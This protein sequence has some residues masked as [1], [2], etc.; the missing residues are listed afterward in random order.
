MAEYSKKHRPDEVVVQYLDHFRL[1]PRE[2]LQGYWELQGHGVTV[3]ATDENIKEE[4]LLLIKAGIAG[5]ESRRTSGRV[6]ANMSRLLERE[7]RRKAAARTQA[8]VP[9]QR[10]S[11]G[12][13]PVRSPSRP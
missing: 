3:V 7:P 10:G 1:N 2:I 6:R 11:S 13:R 12:N 8:G 9:R 4:L 5:A